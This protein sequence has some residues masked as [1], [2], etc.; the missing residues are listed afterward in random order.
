[1]RAH[2]FFATLLFC[3][4]C[5]AQ[6]DFSAPLHWEE[7][8]IRG[9]F[10]ALG[11]TK[12]GNTLVMLNGQGAY[13]SADSG[14]TWQLRE[15]YDDNIRRVASNGTMMVADFDKMIY[16]AHGAGSNQS[17]TAVRT[18][19][20]GSAQAHTELSAFSE[21]GWHWGT[22]YTVGFGK[23]MGDS[24]LTTLEAWGGYRQ[25]TRRIWY[26]N[27]GRSLS[28]LHDYIGR[29]NGNECFLKSDHLLVANR[30]IPLPQPH[31]ET[32]NVFHRGNQWFILKSN[33]TIW[34]KRDS[35]DWVQMVVPDGQ[36]LDLKQ[37]KDELVV[38]TPT[39]FYKMHIKQPNNWQP[40]Y[41][42]NI[43]LP[44]ML[45]NLFF[46]GNWIMAAK[47]GFLFRSL[48][49]G[50]TWAK[51]TV[52]GMSG[53]VI[54]GVRQGLN[55]K[56]LLAFIDGNKF[57]YMP[58]DSSGRPNS[59]SI[60]TTYFSYLPEYQ[61]RNNL[62]MRSYM[63]SRLFSYSLDTG[64]TWFYQNNLPYNFTYD[65]VTGNYRGEAA[66]FI[67]SDYLFTAGSNG[68]LYKTALRQLQQSCQNPVV[69]HSATFDCL[70][71]YI[72]FGDTIRNAGTYN[73][74]VAHPVCDTLHQL[75]FQRPTQS[76]GFPD[77]TIVVP[78]TVCRGEPVQFRGNSYLLNNDTTIRQTSLTGCEIDYQLK[79]NFRTCRQVGVHGA[80]S[81]NPTTGHVLVEFNAA[82]AT[83]GMITISDM[84]GQIVVENG[85]D[86][87]V[88]LNAVPIDI[89]HLPRGQYFI[90]IKFE[91]QQR[92]FRIMKI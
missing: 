51:I 30:A 66:F 43:S 82:I 72:F 16:D 14:S 38:K 46:F 62:K 56:V 81:P 24:L 85:F 33:H 9:V 78:M 83:T 44:E 71:P 6:T 60:L 37:Y 58:M 47:N 10:N 29:V 65:P 26:V 8:P 28:E 89:T 5:S 1:M 57:K 70:N 21:C 63:N 86:V 12:N 42:N 76:G 59:D 17:S 50:Q 49:G 35:A 15:T 92:I 84:M 25:E 64:R 68:K 41:L 22:C 77:T 67:L 11:M 48:N 73:K 13:E 79:I 2:F 27:G 52:S 80:I 18:F 3:N 31:I 61:I 45:D 20:N 4:L 36:A 54:T 19:R 69:N 91:N 53:G 34:T 32:S 23:L 39:G 74:F 75:T 7:V 87:V 90:R 88:G 55:Q 40:V